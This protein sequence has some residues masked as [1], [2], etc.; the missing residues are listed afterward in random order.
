LPIVY[1]ADS[2]AGALIET[3]VHLSIHE[4]EVPLT[5][6]LLRIATPDTL[7]IS[8]LVAPS[9]EPWRQAESTSRALGYAWLAARSS[10][11]A[12]V[13][14]VI[15]PDTF[16]Y[17]LNPLHKDAARLTIV[18]AQTHSFDRRLIR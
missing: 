7:P 8:D 9:N 12:R 14:S 6:K 16:N 3:L 15:A 1:L 18:H 10:A 17:L 2:P 11:L 5:Y 4:K 13:P